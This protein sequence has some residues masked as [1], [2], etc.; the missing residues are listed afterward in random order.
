MRFAVFFVPIWITFALSVY[1]YGHT[2]R[3]LNKYVGGGWGRV[4]G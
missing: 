1:F 4:W 2:I 3:V